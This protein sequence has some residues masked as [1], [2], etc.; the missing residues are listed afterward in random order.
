M[1]RSFRWL[2]VVSLLAGIGLS[3]CSS[4]DDPVAFAPVPIPNQSDP[5]PNPGSAPP[6]P[7]PGSPSTPQITPIPGGTPTPLPGSLPTPEPDPDPADPTPVPTATPAPGAPPAG[8]VIILNSTVTEQSAGRFQISV[9]IPPAQ[10][11][12][13]S[14]T[15]PALNPDDADPLYERTSIELFPGFT[16]FAVSLDSSFTL[17]EFNQLSIAGV[18]NAN[19]VIVH[20]PAFDPLVPA[21][22]FAVSQGCS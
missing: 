14:F 5:T 9:Q 1:F 17:V 11:T 6:L 4:S 15:I 10:L 22:Q 20:E 21:N 8:D 18:T 16:S 19:C 12:T 3:G 7:D 2:T 13:S